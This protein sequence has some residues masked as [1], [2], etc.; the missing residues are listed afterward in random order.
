M[1]D[2]GLLKIKE[3]LYFFCLRRCEPDYIKRFCLDNF[4][5]CFLFIDWAGNL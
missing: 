5:D 3:R 4:S 1:S 2:I